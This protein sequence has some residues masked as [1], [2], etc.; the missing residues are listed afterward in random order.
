MNPYSANGK[1]QAT[2]KQLKTNKFAANFFNVVKANTLAQLLLILSIPVLAR[3]YGPEAFG[4][5]AVFTATLQIAVT[6]GTLKYERLIPNKISNLAAGACLFAGFICLIITSSL[7]LVLTTQARALPASFAFLQNLGGLI[8]LLPLTVFFV[9]INQ[10]LNGWCV[11]H[12]KLH[13]VNRTR[14]YQ[15]ISYILAAFTIYGITQNHRGLVLSTAISSALM[16]LAYRSIYKSAIHVALKPTLSRLLYFFQKTFLQACTMTVVAFVNVVSSLAPILIISLLYTSNDLGQYSLVMRLI[17]TPLAVI[18][19]AMALSF[20]TH[21][22]K[23]A[24]ERK[25]TELR[26]SYLNTTK[27][28][29]IPASLVVIGCLIGSQFITTLLGN[30]WDKTG[31][32]LIYLI[33]MFLGISLVSPTNHLIVLN[34]EKLQLL[35]DG[36]R[37]GLMVII[38]FLSGYLK[39]E[40]TTTVLLLSVASMIGHVGLFLTQLIVHRHLSAA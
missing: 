4:L 6:L 36:L 7:L 14:I 24:R 15:A 22:A 27:I 26:I 19:G 29:L 3:F 28:L 32:I 16:F 13:L 37:L 10:L 31:T 20:W 8:Y 11:R 34:K 35:S 38:Y 30:E 1:L 39:L 40:L 2:V 9:G 21:S 17:G 12:D 25:Y 33:P 5:L 18:T 23:L